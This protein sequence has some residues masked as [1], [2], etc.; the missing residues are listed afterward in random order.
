MSVVFPAGF[1]LERLVK[2]HPRGTF[3]CGETKVD[4]WLA[5][6]AWQQQQKHLS[7]TQV[8]LDANEAIAGYYTLA[9][10][11]IDFSD[12]PA[13]IN[14][15]L[16]QRLLPAA[17]LAW[18]GVSSAHQRQGLGQRLLGHALRSCYDVSATLPFVA[19]MLDCINEETIRFYASWNFQHSPGT[20]RRMFLEANELQRILLFK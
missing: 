20:T 3:R 14:K 5:N 6:Q 17:V 2:S 10:G 19:I 9:M 4:Q 16:P 15:K 18:L 8:L 7:T 13:A 12:L 1:R 11:Q